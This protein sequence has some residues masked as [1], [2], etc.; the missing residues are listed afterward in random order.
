MPADGRRVTGL[1]PPDRVHAWLAASCAAQGVAVV[2]SD[3]LVLARVAVLVSGSAGAARRRASAEAGPALCSQPPDGLD[4]LDV[5]CPGAG[6]AGADDDVLDQGSDHGRL[7]V[8]VQ[9]PP[10]SA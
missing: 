6:G 3:P 10:L 2:V 7:P 9:R 8:Q 5:Q 4:P 1:P